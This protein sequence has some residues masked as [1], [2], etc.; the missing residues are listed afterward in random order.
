MFTLLLGIKHLLRIDLV[1]HIL[2]GEGPGETS[3]WKRA[4]KE[5]GWIEEANTVPERTV[6]DSNT[7]GS[8][9]WEA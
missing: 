7:E 5:Q 1:F 8:I 2:H 4:T 3:I 6:E 9:I